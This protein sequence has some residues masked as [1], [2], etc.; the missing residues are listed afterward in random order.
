MAVNPMVLEIIRGSLSSTIREMELLMERCA[1][2]PF[3]LI[4]HTC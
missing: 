2:S 4:I 3:I 1:L